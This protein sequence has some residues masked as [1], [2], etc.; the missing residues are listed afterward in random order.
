MGLRRIK[1][2][3]FFFFLRIIMIETEKWLRYDFE[4]LT[5]SSFHCEQE[6]EREK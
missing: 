1:E 4:S 2:I 6:R 5:A 3:F